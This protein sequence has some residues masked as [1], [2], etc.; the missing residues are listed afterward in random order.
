M[1][2]LFRYQGFRDQ[3]IRS[4]WIGVIGL[5]IRRVHKKGEGTIPLGPRS[6]LTKISRR[7][8]HFHR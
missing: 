1:L 7:G 2:E 4:Q 3:H 6:S 5:Y 8:D